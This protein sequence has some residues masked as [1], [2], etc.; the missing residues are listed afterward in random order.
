MFEAFD[1]SKLLVFIKDA[2]STQR[3]GIVPLAD[4]VF[5]TFGVEEVLRMAIE[6]CDVLLLLEIRPA[7]DAFL[8]TMIEPI[9]ESEFANT[10]DKRY[11]LV[12]A[13]EPI[14]IQEQVVMHVLFQN[15]TVIDD[16][17]DSEQ[18]QDEH[19]HEQEV[20]AELLILELLD[21]FL[22]L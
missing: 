15:E 22:F 16:H 21:F 6:P 2:M 8:F 3:T 14:N 20:V 10:I 5:D 11:L 19:A 13:I 7:Y 9:L 12:I 1:S 18:T 17:E 4:P